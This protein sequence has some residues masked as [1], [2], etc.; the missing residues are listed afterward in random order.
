MTSGVDEHGSGWMT[1]S[2]MDACV[3]PAPYYGRSHIDGWTEHGGWHSRTDERMTFLV[4]CSLH[5]RSQIQ[6]PVPDPL[7]RRARRDILGGCGW[8]TI[9]WARCNQASG[10]MVIWRGSARSQVPSSPRRGHCFLEGES[11]FWAKSTLMC[12]IRLSHTILS[13]FHTILS[14]Y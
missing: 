12:A 10:W 6:A 3:F 11:S 14:M 9:R 8:M 1:K 4:P 5:V 7:A 2:E 13:T